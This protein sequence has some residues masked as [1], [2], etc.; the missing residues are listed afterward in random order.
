MLKV[1][2]AAKRLYSLSIMAKQVENK[3]QV[4]VD[5][6]PVD[7]E[8]PLPQQ[9]I[10]DKPSPE[11]KKPLIGA[12]HWQ[13]FRNWYVGHK[14]W[15]IPLSI[16]LLLLILLAVPLTRYKVAGLVLKKDF[17]L[18]VSDLTTN[19]PVSGASVSTG[20]IS[21]LTDGN[22]KAKL[23]L[24]VGHHN[25][26]ISKKYY[27]DRSA[28]VLVPILGQK[29]IPTIAAQATGRQVKI[30]VKNSVSKK[31]LENV[32]IN[33][34]DITAKTDKNGQAL[35]VLP[36]G[37]ASQKAK[38][39]LANYNDAEVTVK[40]SDTKVEENDLS[41][42][43][44]GKIYFLSKL[45]G[46]IDVVKSNLDGTQR[47]TVLG[48]TGRED[49]QS[50]VLL[51]SRDWKYL[52][53]LSRRDSDLAKLYLIE[54]STDK[55][56][57]VD[58][59][60]A[61]FELIGWADNYF[62]YLVNRLGYQQWQPKASALK[63]YNAPAKK[64]AILDETDA[65]GSNNNNANYENFNDAYIVGS[66]VVFSKSWYGDYSDSAS[67][68]DNQLAIF[69]INVSG[70]T[71][72]TH[73]TFGYAAFESTY[74]QSFPNNPDQIYYQ[75]VEKSGQPKFFAWA[76]GQVSEK[77]EIKKDFDNYLSSGYNTYLI[78]PSGSA[79]FWSESRDGKN[80]LF[81]GGADGVSS[82]QIATLSDYQTYGWYSGDYLLVSKNG[83]EL[84]IFGSDGIK[85]D[86]E[87]LKV[88]DY[89]KPALSYPAYGG[90]YG[91]I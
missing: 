87:A 67:L 62:V 6:P 44:A 70:G 48:G 19:T 40:V 51:A 58:E 30:T 32:D 21:A 49:N 16:L 74:L 89:H 78:S 24:S 90:G 68:E 80:S 61:N 75:V 65:Q 12:G 86:S 55:V 85:K 14:K 42:T 88:T 46:K 60:N 33:V 54:T 73:K 35:V 28:K 37:V 63:S 29:A 36:A 66:K 18:L 59:G 82:K 22:G 69:S 43:P 8:L 20:S 9:P 77:A 84:Y 72:S 2:K 39:S 23:R 81:T 7:V 13:R 17:T 64:I 15:S 27:Q 45:S 26:T 4:P 38:L 56:T 11:A 76:N 3:E 57:A 25:V 53:L 83:S 47:E 34:S 50:T 10:V 79:T 1:A 91:G 41:L 52:A 5:Q 71:R 31:A